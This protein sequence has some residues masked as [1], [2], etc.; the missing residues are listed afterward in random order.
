MNKEILLVAQLVANEKGI[1]QEDVFEALEAALAGVAK[2][3]FPH[4]E[5][6]EKMEAALLK[7]WQ[8]IL[9]E[10]GDLDEAN[11]LYYTDEHNEAGRDS[12]ADVLAAFINERSGKKK[13]VY[14][15]N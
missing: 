3:K 9:L 6:A 7:L 10:S 14:G 8:K 12:H 15:N 13:M 2:K 1:A 5:E 11:L 4:D